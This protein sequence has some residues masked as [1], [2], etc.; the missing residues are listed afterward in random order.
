MHGKWSEDKAMDT[1]P[2]KTVMRRAAASE[3]SLADLPPALSR[4]YRHRGVKQVSEVDYSLGNLSRPDGLPGIDAAAEIVIDAMVADASILIVGDYDAD[5]ATGCALGY[6]ALKD[7]GARHVA[8]IAPDRF[9]FGYGLT[10]KLVDFVAA[11]ALPDL[12]ITVDNGISSVAGVMRA[13]EKG[14]TVVVTDHHLPGDDLPQADVIVNP[15]LPGATF[16]SKN[17]AG[18]GVIFY[19]MSVVRSRLMED[20]WFEREGIKVPKMA[21]YLDLVAL[22]TIADMVELDYNN[23]VLVAQGLKRINADAGRCRVG[24]RALLESGR[25]RIG[26]ITA[27]DLAFAAAPR[28]NAAGRMKDITIGIRCL[29]SRSNSEVI[30]FMAELEKLNQERMRIQEDMVKEAKSELA[31]LESESDGAALS[32]CYYK[33]NW[34]QGIVG[35]V[36]SQLVE[37]TGMPAAAFARTD[38][39]SLR[40]SCRS[41][42]GVNVRDVLAEVNTSNGDMLIAFGGHAMA[43]GLTIKEADLERF[44]E[45]FNAEVERMLEGRESRGEVWTDGE[46]D[47]INVATAE[48]LQ[49]GGPWGVGFPE[50]LFDGTFT[51]VDH[52]LIK[53]R[54]L[55]IRIENRERTRRHDAT[56]FNYYRQHPDPPAID[57]VIRIVYRIGVYNSGTAK[58]LRMAIAHM[59]PSTWDAR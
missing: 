45:C 24:I 33:E 8:F 49:T 48:A 19:L 59:E 35:L 41:V 57:S 12:I 37:A 58:N 31:R 1:Q 54:H 6:L 25:R 56:Y 18:V 17:L 7:M 39:G 16:A 27:N 2:G 9:E 44:S 52:R 10:E 14:V 26:A 23:R 51:V 20:H 34:H 21:D 36:A 53:E 55:S 50:P 4:V 29:I 22:G 15:R 42:A 32:L 38:G 11:E 5:G 40:G 47:E 3:G 43:A 46:L 28:L 30:K 13:K